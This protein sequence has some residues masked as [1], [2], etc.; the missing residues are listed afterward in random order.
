MQLIIAQATRAILFARTTTATFDW[1]ARRTTGEPRVAGMPHLL[2][3]LEHC[4]RTNDQQ[5]SEVAAIGFHGSN[6]DQLEDDLFDR[7][8]A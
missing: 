6:P 8:Q 1:L 5:L 2:R 4:Q 3:S 7:L